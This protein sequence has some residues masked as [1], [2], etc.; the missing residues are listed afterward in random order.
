MN[1]WDALTVAQTVTP[2][3]VAMMTALVALGFTQVVFHADGVV[4][5]LT[6]GF[7]LLYLMVFLRTAYW[8][9]LPTWIPPEAWEAWM[10]I[11][12]G[13]AL[14][15]VFHA[16]VIVASYYSLKAVYR[17]IPEVDRGRFT[18]FTAPF[19]RIVRRRRHGGRR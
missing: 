2:Y 11:T 4:K 6:L 3:V 1:A 8:D 12:G 7:L 14:N 16:L 9:I 13:T 18:P 19:Y 5:Y 15:V 10:D 17:A